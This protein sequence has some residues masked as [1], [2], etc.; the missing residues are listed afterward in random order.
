MQTSWSGSWNVAGFTGNAISPNL[1]LYSTQNR[2]LHGPVHS[3]A[4]FSGPNLCAVLRRSNPETNKHCAVHV[5][6]TTTQLPPPSPP[7][8]LP[9]PRH[10][11]ALMELDKIIMIRMFALDWLVLSN[12]A[13]LCFCVVLC[14]TDCH[15]ATIVCYRNTVLSLSVC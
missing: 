2:T 11:C 10:W 13:N 9:P 6:N 12:C 1:I 15:P 3:L 8:P 7:S 4:V 14:A 5:S